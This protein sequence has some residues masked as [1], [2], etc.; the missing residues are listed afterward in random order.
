MSCSHTPGANRFRK[1]AILRNDLTPN[2]KGLQHRFEN[3]AQFVGKFLYYIY[4]VDIK[5]IV[6][7][8]PSVVLIQKENTTIG[9]NP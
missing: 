3:R 4:N 8:N 6:L 2:I 1:R 5:G 7:L 9:G